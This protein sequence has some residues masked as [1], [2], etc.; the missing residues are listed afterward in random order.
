MCGHEGGP[1]TKSLAEKTTDN[2]SINERDDVQICSNIESL[3]VGGSPENTGVTSFVQESCTQVEVLGSEHV[4]SMLFKR[5][6]DIQ[7]LT[8][9]FARP[10]LIYNNTVLTS[11]GNVIYTQVAPNLVFNTWYVNGAARLTGVYGVKYSLVFT[12]QVAATPFHQGALALCWQYDSGFNINFNRGFYPYACT[13]I[14]HVVLDMSVDTM[15]Q[16]KVPYLHPLEFLSPTTGN[17]NAQ[18]FVFITQ[19]AGTPAVT[20]MTTPTYKL[21][22]HLEDMEFS[23]ASPLATTTIALQSG[24][25]QKK[26]GGA[27]NIE[28]E[29]AARPY[30]TTTRVASSVVKMVARNVPN[31]SYLATPVSW[32]LDSASGVL[33][34]FGYSKPTIKDPPQRMLAA[35]TALECNV[36][37]P[38]AVVVVGPQAS[39]ELMFDGN[40]SGSNVDEM[41]LAYVMGQWSQINYGSIS[42]IDTHN[43]VVYA[44]PV[45]PSTCWYRQGISQPYCNIFN[46]LTVGTASLNSF[47]P[48][49][50]FYWASMFRAW[51]GNIKYR[52]TFFKTK[53]HAG[54]YML[55]FTPGVQR[56]GPT[57]IPGSVLGPEIASSLLQPFGH[58]MVIDLKD[59][60]VFEFEVPF[61]SPAPYLSFGDSVGSLV[62]S[63]MDPLLASSVIA[64]SVNFM[65][66]VAA[67]ADFEVSIPRGPLYPPV[68]SGGAAIK[69]QSGEVLSTIPDTSSMYTIGEKINSV[70][71]LIMLPNHSNWAIPVGSQLSLV[72]PWWYTATPAPTAPPANTYTLPIG[73]FHY[74][75]VAAKCYAFCRGSTDFHIYAEASEG[76]S[77]NPTHTNDF[78]SLTAANQFTALNAPRGQYPYNVSNGRF[79][80]HYRFPYYSLLARTW[81]C[82]MDIVS[83]N[84]VSSPNPVLTA[85][86][87]YI[88]IVFPAITTRNS[89]GGPIR[90]LTSRCAGDDAALGIYQGP[91]PLYLPPSTSTV[92]FYETDETY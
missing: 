19:L 12:L 39:N 23:G 18:G 76:L 48:S 92:G 55:T 61:T 52:F 17:A 8:E 4:P 6:A 47:M 53:M 74:G 89:T 67:A 33:S 66:E 64:T 91:V 13:N 79:V 62:L 50:L 20:G 25:P 29:F 22:V 44:T 78:G 45:S 2:T 1:R 7:N 9:Y 71:Q 86:G 75:G 43:A 31:L 87:D 46:P 34:S 36:D 73:A 84:L 63:V 32:F 35:N 58:S 77:I 14:P 51:R 54:R 59:E 85:T 24:K 21:Y 60:N 68:L 65:V 16:L 57:D 30:S 26:R 10:R 11:R 15:V 83:W 37:M 72:M 5:Q 40:F 70:K 41:S 90:A 38:Q 80:G 81:T 88:P 56:G 3:S 49:S 27:M 42:T 82:L 28:S 69:T